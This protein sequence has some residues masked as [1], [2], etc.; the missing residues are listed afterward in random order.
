MAPGNSGFFYGWISRQPQL[1]MALAE[2]DP[3][4]PDQPSCRQGAGRAAERRGG[5]ASWCSSARH[6]PARLCCTALVTAVRGTW[7]TVP[8]PDWHSHRPPK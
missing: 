2:P 3:E 5:E 8:G 1:A 6:A 4:L 7:L